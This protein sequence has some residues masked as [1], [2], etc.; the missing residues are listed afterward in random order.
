VDGV[1]YTAIF[2]VL[3][4]MDYYRFVR[5]NRAVSFYKEY[6]EIKKNM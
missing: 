5:G 4:A 6:L 1:F 3:F 2:W